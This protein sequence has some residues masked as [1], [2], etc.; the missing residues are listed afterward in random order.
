MTSSIL[1]GQ[2]GSCSSSVGVCVC[3]CVCVQVHRQH[4]LSLTE[5]V[6]QQVLHDKSLFEIMMWLTPPAPWSYCDDPFKGDRNT[7]LLRGVLFALRT[8]L[9]GCFGEFT[10]SI[11][12]QTWVLWMCVGVSEEHSYF[13]AVVSGQPVHYI[14]I[15]KHL[16]CK[17]LQPTCLRENVPVLTV[18][19]SG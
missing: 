5:H 7:F 4:C 15:E 9:G 6:W 2:T 17:A 13:K 16:G 10:A 18:S 11:W 19:R 3:V 1:R 8:P 14:H 12:L